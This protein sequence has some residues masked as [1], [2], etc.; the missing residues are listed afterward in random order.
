MTDLAIDLKVAEG[1]V[2]LGAEEATGF[3][4]E[5]FVL[6]EVKPT[7][8]VVD[9]I[10]MTAGLE[11]V[12]VGVGPNFPVGLVERGLVELGLVSVLHVTSCS[13]L[14]FVRPDLDCSIASPSVAVGLF[15]RCPS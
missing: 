6:E 8:G 7:P 9:F 12:I 11:R 15:S 2:D 3:V 13:R 4:V 10:P 5:E 1:S 14:P